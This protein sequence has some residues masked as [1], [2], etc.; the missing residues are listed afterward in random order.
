MRLFLHDGAAHLQILPR[1]RLLEFRDVGSARDFLRPLLADPLNVTA[2]RR[3][4]GLRSGDDDAL[5]QL[6]ARMVTEGLQVV[7]CREAFYGFVPIDATVDGSAASAQNTPLQD[8]EAAKAEQAAAPGPEEKH[9]IEIELIDDAGN[10]VAGEL[11]FVELPDGSTLSGR[12]DGQG[13]ARVD[14]V[15]PGTAKV[16]FPD[17]DKSLYTPGGGS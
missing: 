4:L 16:S 3:A 11:Y 17:L 10:P 1:T 7:S 8:E 13:R 6:A 12:T 2:V 5:E 15:D 9:W 14:G